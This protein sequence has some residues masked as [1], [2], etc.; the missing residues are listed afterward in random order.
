MKSHL[1]TASASYFTRQ[2]IDTERAQ[3]VRA[4]DSNI[5][6]PFTHKFSYES[7]VFSNFTS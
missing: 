4:A 3:L 6:L 7:E 2:K 1:Q 5:I